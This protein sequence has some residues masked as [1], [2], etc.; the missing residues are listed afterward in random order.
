MHAAVP[1]KERVTK[2][3]YSILF[4]ACLVLE[5]YLVM[6]EG[7][8]NMVSVYWWYISAALYY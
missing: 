8:V 7:A 3:F 2:A 6:V 4:V 5:T 1:G